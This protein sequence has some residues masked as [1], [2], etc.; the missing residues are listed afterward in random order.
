TTVVTTNAITSIALDLVWQNTDTASPHDNVLQ[1]SY[2]GTLY[3]TFTTGGAAGSTNGTW[4]YFNGASGTST[5]VAGAGGAVATAAMTNNVITLG[6]PVSAS[7]NLVFTF[8]NGPSGSGGSDDVAI[9]NVV[10]T[11]SQTT[12]TTVT[13]V[14]LVNNGWSTT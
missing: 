1:V 12:S 5:T 9:D 2:G 8:A 11:N 13:A 7:G 14:D 6:T 3:A 10:V 4:A